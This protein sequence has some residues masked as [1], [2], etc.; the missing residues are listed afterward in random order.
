MKDNSDHCDHAGD[1]GEHGVPEV[2]A[3]DDGADHADH[4]N[5]WE[6]QLAKA[7]EKLYGFAAS[8][9]RGRNV[10]PRD[11]V[12]DL[13]VRIL[14][15]DPDPAKL[16]TGPTAY[17]M[18]ILRNVW[19]DRLRREIRAHEESLEDENG[20]MKAG[21]QPIVAAD[22]ERLLENRELYELLLKH[23]GP[24]NPREECIFMMHID[25]ADNDEIAHYLGAVV[26]VVAVELNAV[27]AKVRY[28]IRT[29]CAGLLTL[30]TR[31]PK[32]KR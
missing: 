8:L 28:R 14:R 3:A 29:R 6:E 19:N 12:S 21:V 31:T 22:A 2:Q 15:Y 7:S 23:C 18:T 5:F 11:L 10:D 20:E 24:L 4:R 13:A 25:G 26:E 16:T 30:K 17:L 9:A 1:H 27:K 32:R